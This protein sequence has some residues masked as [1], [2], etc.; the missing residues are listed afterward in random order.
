MARET[1]GEELDE[2]PGTV[3]LPSKEEELIR[4]LLPGTLFWG[5]DRGEGGALGL[6]GDGDC[7]GSEGRG[8]CTDR[9]ARC[10][11]RQRVGSRER[12]QWRWGGGAEGEPPRDA[13]GASGPTAGGD[14]TGGCGSRRQIQ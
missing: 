6:R 14:G 12:R 4:E 11:H 7:A 8:G 13:S 3:E 10:S 1:A 9:R 2:H 5:D